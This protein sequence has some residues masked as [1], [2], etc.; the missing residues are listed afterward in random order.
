LET[1]KEFCREVYYSIGDKRYFGLGNPH[2]NGWAIRN[3]YWKGC[4]A[5]GF[6]HY[7]NNAANLCLFEGVFDLLSYVEMRKSDRYRQDFMVLNSLANLKG[8]MPEIQ[9]YG[10]VALFLDRD[11]AGKEATE[12]LVQSLPQCRDHSEFILP[13]K[14]LNEC[15]M[16]RENLELK[17]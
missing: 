11:K 5:Q 3:K 13:Y 8:A 16:G 10:Q 9:K 17:R 2:E 7:R 1:A 14:D 6:S 15:W 4:T 12:Q